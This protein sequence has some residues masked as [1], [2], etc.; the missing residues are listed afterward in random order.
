MKK[1]FLLVCFIGIFG[2]ALLLNASIG[3]A[4]S[5]GFYLASAAGTSYGSMHTNINYSSMVGTDALNKTQ[6]QLE[7]HGIGGEVMT[8]QSVETPAPNSPHIV[9]SQTTQVMPLANSYHNYFDVEEKAATGL[10]QANAGADQVGKYQAAVG[11]GMG[12]TQGVLNSETFTNN[13]A[14]GQTIANS[15][16][17]GI[18]ESGAAAEY[19][20][21][22]GEGVAGADAPLH[23]QI[24]PWNAN[25]GGTGAPLYE[26]STQR[27]DYGI[28]Q[29]GN[30]TYS[31]TKVLYGPTPE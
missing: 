28:T 1:V 10:I 23:D 5:M 4:E 9:A 13:G 30:W 11:V 26:L 16:G 8:I 12:V 19:S 14:I 27:V 31:A 18:L 29:I 17:V 2:V 22:Q 20:L 25:S 24:C 7:N 6:Y 15:Y 3:G 21:Y